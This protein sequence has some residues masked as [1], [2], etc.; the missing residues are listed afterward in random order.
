MVGIIKNSFYKA[1]G[2]FNLTWFKL[3]D[4]LLDVEVTINNRPLCYMEDDI[5]LPL[6]TSNMMIL[7]SMMT[8][9]SM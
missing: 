9:D 4:V 5:E 2:S 6:L 8:L 7:D 3:E 1:I